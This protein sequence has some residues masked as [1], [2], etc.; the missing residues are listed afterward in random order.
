MLINMNHSYNDIISIKNLCE[1]WRE[2]VRGK[3]FRRDVMEFSLN[4]SENIIR[5]HED[6]KNRTYQHSVYKAFSINDPKPR[7]IHKA[8]VRDRLLHHAIYR[9]LYP[10]FDKKFIYDSYSC[11]NFKGTHRP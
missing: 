5:L 10:Y 1:A 6:L 3:K 4:L 8:E 7:S 2:F 9:I 11:R